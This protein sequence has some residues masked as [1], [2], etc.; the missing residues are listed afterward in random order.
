[1]PKM[2][3]NGTITNSHPEI[4]SDQ[5][6]CAI[7]ESTVEAMQETTH[8]YRALFRVQR[9]GLYLMADAGRAVYGVRGSW[10]DER[11]LSGAGPTS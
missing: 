7:V 1:M 9:A 10:Q 6:I 4:A 11:R 3:A 5:Q 8:V 2:M